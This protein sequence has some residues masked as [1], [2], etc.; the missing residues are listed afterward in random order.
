MDSTK[1]TLA[2]CML[3]IFGFWGITF[4]AA[5]MKRQEKDYDERQ[6]FARGRAY[7]SGFFTMILLIV[8][9]L[10]CYEGMNIRLIEPIGAMVLVIVAGFGAFLIKATVQDALFSFRTKPN[11]GRYVAFY[12]F[13]LTP[14]IQNMMDV[15]K[16]TPILFFD[17]HGFLT[18]R[19]LLGGIMLVIGIVGVLANLMKSR[20]DAS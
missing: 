18:T 5:Y 9:Y 17:E 4:Y 15:I 7:R 8:I 10:F 11:P 12:P 2:I 14:V 6:E 1:L 16:G 20:E 13:I 3:L 19:V